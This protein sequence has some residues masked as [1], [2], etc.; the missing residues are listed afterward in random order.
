[1]QCVIGAIL[2]GGSLL[3]PESPRCGQSAVYTSSEDIINTLSDGS[4]IQTKTRMA[5][6]YL[7]IYTVATPIVSPLRR[8]SKKSRTGSCWRYGL[9]CGF[10][11]LPN[12]LFL[13]AR[14]WRGKVIRCYVEEVQASHFIGHVFPS[15]CSACKS[16]PQFNSRFISELFHARMVSTV[17]SSLHTASCRNNIPSLQVISYYARKT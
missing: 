5:C 14:V 13:P 11:H 1:M 4:L 15:L 9:F 2:A 17:C 3:L 16:N 7:P 6:G 12:T 10:H 8:N